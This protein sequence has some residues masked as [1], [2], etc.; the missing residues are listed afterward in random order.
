MQLSVYTEE[1][2]IVCTDFEKILSQIC[3]L[4][5]LTV[6]DFVKLF[7]LKKRAKFDRALGKFSN[8]DNLNFF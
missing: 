2:T 8:D 7:S 5:R 4:Q 6:S 1:H 3:F